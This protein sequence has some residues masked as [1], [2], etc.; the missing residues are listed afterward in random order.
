MNTGYFSKD[1]LDKV[2]DWK[3]YNFIDMNST[4]ELKDIE[5]YFN[6]NPRRLYQSLKRLEKAECIVEVDCE[7]YTTCGF[8][9]NYPEPCIEHY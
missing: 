3:I 5:F 4:C 9:S 1:N 6:E 2:L 8:G 7:E